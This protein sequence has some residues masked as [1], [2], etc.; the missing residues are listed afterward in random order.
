MVE[1]LRVPSRFG[2]DAV[3][4]AF[5]EEFRRSGL[6]LAKIAFSIAALMA[7]TFWAVLAVAPTD[8]QVSSVRQLAR[9]V[10]AIVLGLT[11]FY[12]HFRADSAIKRFPLTVGVPMALACLLLGSMGLMPLD[13]GGLAV[14]RFVVAMAITCWLC[15]GFTRLPTKFVFLICVPASLL[16]LA[17]VALQG[18]DHTLALSIYL[19]AANTVGWVMSVEIE[20]RER[21]LFWSSRQLRQTTHELEQMARK[22]NQAHEAKTRVLAAV[23]HDLRQPLASLTLYAQL[24]REN[25]RVSRDPTV[26]TTVDSLDAC[27]VALSSDL[28]RLSE[29]GL[30]DRGVP[31]PAQ[32]VDLRAV[33]QRIERVYSGQAIRDGIRLVVRLP[34]PRRHVVASNE[35]RL[36][37]VLANLVANA[38]K[39]SRPE[40]DAWVLVRT[41]HCGEGLEVVVR[42]N[43]IGISGCDQSRIFDEYF[44]VSNPA[45][46]AKQ[47]QGLGLSIVRETLSRLPGH[48][49]RLVSIPGRGALFAVYLPLATRVPAREL[50]LDRSVGSV[51]AIEYSVDSCMSGV[52]G[53]Y[54]CEPQ[55][56]F[57]RRAVP[58]ET[59]D[60]RDAPPFD[61]PET[62]SNPSTDA[63]VL[64][65]ED[66]E[67]MLVALRRMFERWGF[68]VQAV[69]D[70]EQAIR[71]L[72]ESQ[73]TFD[74]IVSD[75]RL[76]G[77]WDGLRLIEELRRLEGR[78]IP[79]I[80][81]SG[82]FRVE[83]LRCDAPS[84]VEILGKPPDVGRLR[85][86]LA[87]FARRSG[88][89]EPG[90]RLAS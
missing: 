63:R 3:E 23:S 67:T 70:G 47:G 82:E 59:G 51:P 46:S 86:L 73:S 6:R 90:V 43:G 5:L 36:W 37:D 83:A 34:Q 60:V 66:D 75:F 41:R 89:S 53:E 19:V 27:I 44:Q 40:R 33:L 31:L 24:I 45:R 39:F 14:N 80:L 16:T 7:L 28:D 35:S 4:E 56:A 11:A 38:L 13:G 85:E 64:I 78:R 18:D 32:P 22:A 62:G 79:A 48:S 21:A 61:S 71:M 72:L 42:D 81:L 49:I 57:Y 58:K 2:S 69:A 20:R 9:V 76:P 88:T 26:L 50:V 68:T 77:A 12:L 65:V 74:A 30:R 8:A 52:G 84:D 17:G 54:V 55:A 29:L 10:L 87:S 15:Y 25:G 1:A